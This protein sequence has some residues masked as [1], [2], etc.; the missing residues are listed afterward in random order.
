MAKFTLDCAL[1]NHNLLLRLDR[2]EEN[3][4]IMSF[5]GQHE[6]I[7]DGVIRAFEALDLELTRNDVHNAK[8]HLIS[9]KMGIPS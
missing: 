6:E 9:E 5:K 3:V 2:K 1:H 4:A 7:C 8:F